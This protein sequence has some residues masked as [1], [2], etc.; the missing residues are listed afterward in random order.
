MDLFSRPKRFIFLFITQLAVMLLF[1]LT[2]LED[3]AIVNEIDNL[4]TDMWFSRNMYTEN[5]IGVQRHDRAQFQ[6]QS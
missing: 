4:N 5:R 1:S 6:K 3:E 2:M